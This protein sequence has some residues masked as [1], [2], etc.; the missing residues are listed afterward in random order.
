MN[1]FAFVLILVLAGAFSRLIPHEYNLAPVA[2]LGLLSGAVL[3]Q[4]RGQQRGWAVAMPILALLVSD[5]LIF[6]LDPLGTSPHGQFFHNSLGFVL[7]RLFDFGSF[8]LIPFIGQWVGRRLNAQRVLTGALAGSLVF[9]LFS[10]FGYY[11]AQSFPF[12]GSEYPRASLLG[13]YIQAIPFY[14]ATLLGDLAYSALF[15]GAYAYLLRS[16][17]ISQAA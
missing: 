16:R 8:A 5:V 9:F 4:G 13:C 11:L 12:A 10:N 2:A 14:R 6:A 17:R 1:R 7:Q 15:F 3:M